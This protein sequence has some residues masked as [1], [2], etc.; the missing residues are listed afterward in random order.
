MRAAVAIAALIAGGVSIRAQS[1]NTD[2]YRAAVDTYVKTGDPVKAVDGLL[3]SDRDQLAAGVKRVIGSGNPELIEAAAMLHLEIGLAVAG[4]STPAS[5]GY[6]DLGTDLV[7]NLLPPPQIAKGLSQQRIDE[8]LK[9]RTTWLGVAGSAF[10]SVSDVPRARQ[11]FAKAMSPKTA[12]ILTLVGTADELD[13]AIMNPGDVESLLMKTRVQ[14][15]RSRLLLNA[16]QRYL[17]ALD[18][19]PAYPLAQVRLGRVYFL[20]NRLRSAEEWLK[21]GR[22]AAVDPMHKYLAAMFTGALLQ[23]QKDVDGARTAYEQAL[24]LAP[25][26]QNA[27]VALAYVNLISGRPDRAQALTQEFTGLPN[28][29]ESWWSYKNGTLDQEGLYWLRKRVRQ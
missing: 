14:R 18:V 12:R 28:S 21:R 3:G 17:Q 16:E 9:V 19:D 13:G 10:L 2:I 4:I 22:E 26:S 27:V 11:M 29:D 5:A 15:E 7:N 1:S 25:R 23:E 6:L 24:K 20:Q 8:L